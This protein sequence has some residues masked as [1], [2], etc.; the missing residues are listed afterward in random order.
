MQNEVSGLDLFS[1][2]IKK[3]KNEKDSKMKLEY[4]NDL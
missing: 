1:Q 2:K 4:W 3:W